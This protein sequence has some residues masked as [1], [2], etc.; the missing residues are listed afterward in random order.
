MVLLTLDDFDLKG[1][2][3]LLRTDINAPLDPRSGEILDISRIKG[4]IPTLE[5]LTDSK[6]V[7]L[8]HQSRPGKRDF[9]TLERHA[10]VLRRLTKRRVSY[11]DD[12]FGE[13]ARKEISKLENGDIL[14]LENVRFCSEEVSKQIRAKPPIEQARTHLVRKLSSYVD[15]F[16]NDAFAVSHRS[17]PSVVAFPMVLPSCIGPTMEREIN[18]LS[19]VLDSNDAPKVFSLGGAKADDSFQITKNA[20]T[21]GIADKVLLSGVTALIFLIAGGKDIGKANKKLVHD[22]GFDELIPEAKDLLNRFRDK[23]E[24]PVDMAFERDGKR[25]E[26]PVERFPDKKALDIGKKT[27]E[28][29]SKEINKAKTVIAKGPTGVFEMN[30]FALGTEG[31][32]ESIATSSALSVV[33]GGHLTTVADAAG[34]RDRITHIGSGGG[35]TVSFLSEQPLPGIEAMKKAAEGKR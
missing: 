22:M 8:A 24:L 20:L 1:K 13:C 15:F 2:K 35:A 16:V 30:G 32:L 34:L 17:Q 23:I 10:Q 14:V 26:A 31:L 6:V 28:E 25:G 29:F 19:K 4:C 11:V 21:K 18:I 9:T 5:R 27:I 12:V 3:V 7:I 33:G